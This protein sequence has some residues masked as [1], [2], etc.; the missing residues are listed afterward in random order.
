M[1]AARATW[2]DHAEH[3]VSGIENSQHRDPFVSDDSSLL[4]QAQQPFLS[5]V[6][7]VQHR[8]FS[9]DST[10][11]DGDLQM[12]G[13]STSSNNA[14]TT[15]TPA[16]PDPRSRHSSRPQQPLPPRAPDALRRSAT[17]ATTAAT[18]AASATAPSV[19][20][21]RSSRLTSAAVATPTS[22]S[23]T[24]S[25]RGRLRS[26]LLKNTKPG[27]PS[28]TA[29]VPPPISS[30]ESSRRD[31]PVTVKVVPDDGERIEAEAC[32]LSLYETLATGVHALSRFDCKS[33]LQSLE[34]LPVVQ[35]DS[36][37]V[38]SKIGRA[39][40][41]T[42]RYTEAEAC[43]VRLREIDPMRVEDMEIYSTLLWH[44]RKDV[45]LAFLAR[46]LIDIDRYSPQAWIAIGNSFSLQKEHDQALKCFR[47][48]SHLDP[49]F[50][51]PYTLQGHEYV[52]N[53]EYESA[54]NAFRLAMRAD[55][56]H[57]NAWYGIGMLFLKTGKFQLAEQ[58][59]RQAALI[60]P[61]N[62][63]LIC[64]IGM[65][66]E[67]L[68]RFDEALQQYEIACGLQPASAMP[69]FKKARLLMSMRKYSVSFFFFYRFFT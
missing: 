54:Q 50:A 57:Y 39:Y 42:V 61:A 11:V 60:N 36:P 24:G 67:K 31:D 49:T 4:S 2:L 69:R 62:A 55:W 44:L 38:L 16:S 21:R 13:S 26:G 3:E 51:Y 18:A 15:S 1:L 32:M 41:E 14:V 9:P 43:F 12:A 7:N 23:Q 65:V 29:A 20:E 53:E 27:A 34:S 46:E 58:H 30:D 28:A 45:E 35:Q 17:T 5:R 6:E 40:F 22:Q 33:A 63:V 25:V 68:E 48:A 19:S 10:D 52:A 59:F 56:R 47:R 8:L 64:C 37:Y 66:L